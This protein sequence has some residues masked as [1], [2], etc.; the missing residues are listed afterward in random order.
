[1]KKIETI[2]QL[3]LVSLYVYKQLL[4]FCKTNDL[5]VYL[6]GGTLI[7]AI[8]DKGFVKWDDD[9]DVCMSRDDYNRMLKLSDGKISND[10]HIIDPATEKSFKGYISLAVLDNSKLISRQYREIE[11]SKI[12]VSIFIYDGVP[13]CSI[14]R[15]F[16]FGH[17]YFL[18]AQHALCRADFKHVS[19]KLAKIV[20]PFFSKFYSSKRV[21]YY[22][23]KILKLQKKYSYSSSMLVSPNTDTNAWLEVFPKKL[24]EKSVTV[25][26]EGTESKTFSYYDTH[27]RKY[28]G[29]YMT[30]PPC[31]ECVPKHGFDAWVDENFV[32]EETTI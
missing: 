30:P 12:G 28:Y 1:M 25:R 2:R 8:R 13:T 17:M 27:L 14:L 16:Y 31:A 21:Y 7:G 15:K 22:K 18:R 23:N 10:C 4:L 5:N 26:F 19:S 32:F 6:L 29:D 9:I 11:E 20:G 24:F 3:Q